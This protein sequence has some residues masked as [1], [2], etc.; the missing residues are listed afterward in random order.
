[1]SVCAVNM[2][3]SQGT[4]N[5]TNETQHRIVENRKQAIMA[6]ASA[7]VPPPPKSVAPNLVSRHSVVR[8]ALEHMNCVKQFLKK[9]E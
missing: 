7:L 3:E 9:H 2:P 8:T 4:S 5:N 1:M 6:A